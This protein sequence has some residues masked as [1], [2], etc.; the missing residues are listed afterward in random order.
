MKTL[1]S[2]SLAA[3]VTTLIVVALTLLGGTL[4]VAAPVLMTREAEA[5]ALERQETN[6]RVAWEV[7]GRHGSAFSV[8]GDALYVGDTRLNDNFGPV[9]R[10]KTLVG[11]TATVFQGDVRVTTNVSKPDGSRAVGTQLAKG[12]VYDAVLRDG[13]PYRGKADILGTPFFVAYDPIRDASGR[14]IGVLYVGIPQADFMASVTGTRN[15]LLGLGLAVVLLMSGAGVVLCRRMFRPLGALGEAMTGLAEGR[16]DI[17]TPGVSRQ[18]DI[19]RMARAVN[20]FRDAEVARRRLEGEAEA[21]RLETDSERREAE[22]L[23]A[24][25]SQGDQAIILALSQGLEALADGDLTYRIDT[26]LPPKAERLKSDFNLTA[27]RLGGVL[28]GIARAADAL[29]S[30]AAEIRSATDDLSRR[31]EQQ[32]AGLEETAAALDEITATVRQSATGAGE[33]DAAAR[34][35]R[36]AAQAG[37]DVARQ[38]VEAMSEIERSS[39]EISQIIGV[40]DEIAFQTNLLALNAGVEAARA[41][42]AGRGFAVVASEVRGLAQRS[43]DAAK[44]I[45]RLIS[46]SGARVGAGVNLVRETGGVLGGIERQAAAID[47]LV[48]AISASTREQ[49]TGLNQINQAVNQMDQ[50]TQQN[51]AMVEQTTAASHRLADEARRMTD[52]IS[53]FRLPAEE[54]GSG[55]RLAA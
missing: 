47:E 9:D 12:A 8:R 30:G 54:M 15:W 16:T 20:A 51:A 49:S 3:K 39:A 21:A 50:A 38:A 31:T 36:E 37:G 40:I 33:A 52:L 7:L 19:G 23:R 24:A 17:E 28:C 43:A 35:A 14:V 48:A 34:T 53:H 11:G 5:R 13:R 55:G 41:G 18:D 6:M 44:E 25:E 27:E 10:I 42:D 45:K 26:P 4:L 22:R 29:S 2:L 32:A 46:T 1:S